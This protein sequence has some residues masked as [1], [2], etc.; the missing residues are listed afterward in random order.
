MIKSN[1]ESQD[2]GIPLAKRLPL[3]LLK[4]AICIWARIR[5]AANAYLKAI[6]AA[7]ESMLW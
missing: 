1:S 4:L 6:T 2:S 7:I 5:R 3:K